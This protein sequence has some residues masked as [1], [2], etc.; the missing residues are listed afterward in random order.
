MPLNAGIVEPAGS[1]TDR[2]ETAATS[3]KT[4]DFPPSGADPRLELPPF[5]RPWRHPLRSLL[6]GIRTAFGLLSLWLLLAVAA[7]LPLV[8]FAALGWLLDAEGRVARSGRLREG[9][10][11]LP[12][13]PRFGS[14]VLGVWLWLLPLRFASSAAVDAEL[15][16]PGGMEAARLAML[17]RV[18]WAI[19]TVHLCLALAR[20]GSLASFFRP[21]HNVRW[22]WR[23]LR[24]GNYWS[25]AGRAVRGFVS[26]LAPGRAAWRGVRGF[27]VAFVWLAV[28]TAL[29]AALREL[30]PGQGLITILGGVLLVWA[31]AWVP[32][33]QARFT[34]TEQWSSGFEFRA[35]R[36]LAR[37]APFAWTFA[38][39]GVY[40]LSL[41][42]YLTKV[43]LP[44][45]DAMWLLTLVFIAS[46][47]PARVLTGWAYH[48]A[49]DRQ[50]RGLRSRWPARL[51]ARLL[52][53]PL[54]STYVFV[55][56]FTQYISEHG[57]RA[58]FE[59]HALLLPWPG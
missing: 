7:A 30:E 10:P 32:F 38:L 44:P 8:N 43:V 53:L 49:V 14:I 20:G 13:A 59:H 46:I 5:P 51:L 58:L 28:P 29:Y 22:L 25:D 35:T 12:V 4:D 21:I 2:P 27:A 37:H 36:E 6:W 17:T 31:L 15:V 57:K 52:L 39:I 54:L 45:A 33:L 41:P 18:L 48:R 3:V 19:I 24:D 55:L 1:E 23:R 16:S 42:L 56:F 50:R 34:A 11:L 40:V 47:L 9:L 26:Q